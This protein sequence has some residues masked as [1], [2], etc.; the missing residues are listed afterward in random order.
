MGEDET[1]VPRWSLT[2]ALTCNPDSRW[3]PASEVEKLEASLARV[4]AERD[5]YRDS[6]RKVLAEECPSDEQHCAC[7]PVLRKE[8]ARLREKLKDLDEASARLVRTN[9][10]LR[11]ALKPE[12]SD[13]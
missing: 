10:R 5:D 12:A 11:E 2:G 1:K 6:A 3:C 13:E 4:T 9:E 8:N 7:V